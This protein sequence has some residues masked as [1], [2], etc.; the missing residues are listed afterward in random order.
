MFYLLDQSF[1]ELV[2]ILPDYVLRIS[3]G[4]FSILHSSVLGRLG[5]HTE[6]LNGYQLDGI[7][8]H[9]ITSVKKIANV[10]NTIGTP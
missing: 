5:R 2:V 1:S 4:S 10:K 7:L 9:N 8:L 3:L 6:M